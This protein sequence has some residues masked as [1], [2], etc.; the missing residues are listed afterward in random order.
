MGLKNPKIFKKSSLRKNLAYQIL[1]VNDKLGRLERIIRK[2]NAPTIIYV[3]TRKKTKDISNY[4]NAIGFKTTFYNGGLTSIQKQISFRDWFS[5][6]K[7]IMVATNAFG[8][9]IDKSNVRAVIHLDL[10]SSIENYTQEAGRAGRDL[11]KAYSVTL[12][13]ENDFISFIFSFPDCLL[14]SKFRA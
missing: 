6:K 14:I 9:G 7:P 13:N 8:M 4:L 11:K 2:I 5:E 10:P 1:K 3:S 12:V